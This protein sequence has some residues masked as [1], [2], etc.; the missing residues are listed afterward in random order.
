MNLWTGDAAVSAA[1]P[2]WGADSENRTL[3]LAVAVSTILALSVII[4]F[5]SHAVTF[6]HLQE[7]I[8]NQYATIRGEAFLSDGKRLII[9]PFY[10][11]ILFPALFVGFTKLFHGLTDVQAF[12]LLRFICF[13]GCLSAIYVAA[14][15]RAE[16]APSGVMACA[17]AALCMIPTFAHGWVHS[18]D[19]FDLTFCL[20]MFLFIAEDRY[21]MGFFVACLTAVNRETG[22]FAAVAYL[23]FATGREKWS[24]L[25][26][27]AGLLGLVPYFGALVV[28]KLVLGAQLP[29]TSSGQWYTGLAYNLDLWLEALRRPSPI[30]WPML[31]FAMMTFPFLLFLSA[32]QPGNFRIRAIAVFAANFAIIA[33]VGI[34][35]EVRTF[36]PCVGLLIACGIVR[37]D[38]LA[39]QG[40][41]VGAPLLNDDAS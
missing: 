1:K 31:L 2:T 30:G 41:L 27:K 13:V 8:F 17:A 19:I 39:T 5:V 18:S 7:N 23:C 4:E 37:R 34:N 33:A 38:S 28:R 9:E 40:T 36:I 16:G 10:N 35:A 12:V 11:R 24:V 22:A 20:F 32:R 21:W 29:L 25:A 3:Q 14:T 15:R 26:A 6:P